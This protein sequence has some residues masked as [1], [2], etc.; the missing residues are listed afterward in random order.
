MFTL[1]FHYEDVSRQ[2]PL[3]KPNHANVMKVPGSCKIRVVLKATPSDFIIKNGKLAMEIPCVMSLLDFPIEIQEKSIQFLMEMEFCE[4]SP[5]LEDHFEIF[6]H[7][8]GFN[9]TIVTANTQDETLPPWSGFFQKDE[10]KSH[11]TNRTRVSSAAGLQAR[12]TGSN[13]VYDNHKA[14]DHR[15]SRDPRCDAYTIVTSSPPQLNRNTIVT[16]PRNHRD[17]AEP[18]QGP[19]RQVSHDHDEGPYEQVSHDD[20]NLVQKMVFDA[21]GPS[22]NPLE[23]HDSVPQAP[24]SEPPNP[25]AKKFYDL[26]S[27]AKELLYKGCEKHSTLSA[28]SRLLNIKSDFNISQSCYDCIMQAVKEFIPDS[29]LCFNYYE[30]KKIVSQLGLGYQKID[31]YP[32]GCMI[33]YNKE[34]KD[35][36][37]C[38]VCSHPRYKHME[39]GRHLFSTVIVNFCQGII[40]LEETKMVLSRDE[41]RGMNLHLG[42]REL[43]FV[44][45][46]DG[47]VSKPKALFSLTKEQKQVFLQWV[48]KL[49]FPDGYASNLSRCA[50]VHKGKM[51]G[52]KNHDCHVFIERLLPIAFREMLPEPVWKAMTEILPPRFFDHMEHL[53][54]HLSYE[55]RVG[56]PVQY[57][58]MYPFERYLYHLKKKVKNKARVESS[59]CEAYIMEEISNFYSHYFEPHVLTNSTSVKRNDNGSNVNEREDVL[60]IFKH[61]G[62]VKL[63]MPNITNN[64]LVDVTKKRFGHWLRDYVHNLEN[65]TLVNHR[66]QNIALGPSRD[67]ITYPMCYVNGF[68]FYTMH[69]SSGRKTINTDLCLIGEEGESYG[70]LMDIIEVDYIGC[71]KLNTLVLFKC[72]WFDH[73]K[74][75][76]WKVHNEFGLVDINQKKKLLQYDPFIM[77]HQAHQMYFI[78]YPS[79]Q[80]DKIDWWAVCKTKARSTIVAPAQSIDSAYQEDGNTIPFIV[81]EHDEV[82]HLADNESDMQEAEIEQLTY[83]REEKEEEE[84]EEIEEEDEEDNNGADAYT[85]DDDF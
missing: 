84:E 79:V 9:V 83:L 12:G 29:T 10:G 32:N 57:R 64:Q 85:D 61:P 26:V 56:A 37:K 2:D 21:A 70:C 75:Q 63:E 50:D 19:C 62:E 35:K 31:V 60:S 52:M 82:K 8:R 44:S 4:F 66:I 45:D 51:F 40:P 69:H 7:I 49:K 59:I 73:V 43:E 36:D 17:S 14:F 80:R 72:D 77:A 25:E 78:D 74:N 23:F 58:W 71:S 22:F 39:Q 68:C 46:V 16:S 28:M 13:P 27:R 65:Q 47:K 30:S 6:E 33:Y 55:A 41:L 15:I 42:Y 18:S 20:I 81:I 38:Q 1:N 67:V 48:K 76:G 5:E 24:N 54:V 34:N 3:L 53:V 11:Q